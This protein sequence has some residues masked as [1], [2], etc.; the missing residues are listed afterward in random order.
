ME[1][2]TLID[3]TALFDFQRTFDFENLMAG[4]PVQKH[5]IQVKNYHCSSH[6]IKFFRFRECRFHLDLTTIGS[7]LNN[8]KV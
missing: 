1:N 5:M 7:Y 6:P 4:S 2:S 3:N 8:L